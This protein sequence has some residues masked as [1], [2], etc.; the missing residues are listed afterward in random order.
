MGQADRRKH[1]EPADQAPVWGL[2][3]RLAERAGGE[4]PACAI[5][6]P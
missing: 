2:I 5:N 1:R 6:P 4:P 3:G